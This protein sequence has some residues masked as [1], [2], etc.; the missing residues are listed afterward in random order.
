MPD[1][2]KPEAKP[3]TKV[4]EWFKKWTTV[5]KEARTFVIALVALVAAVAALGTAIKYAIDIGHQIS[6]TRAQAKAG[7]ASLSE[8]VDTLSVQT[9]QNYENIAAL[10]EWMTDQQRDNEA[11]KNPPP[12]APVL[13]SLRPVASKATVVASNASK[14]GGLPVASALPTMSSSAVLPPPMVSSVPPTA[15]SS[16]TLSTKALPDI[17]PKPEKIDTKRARDVFK[18]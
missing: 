17:G 11:Y 8:N 14:D 18:D 2:T 13:S 3:E 6:L 4:T 7:V 5:L 10:R 15:Y 9:R 1:E 16:Q 12:P